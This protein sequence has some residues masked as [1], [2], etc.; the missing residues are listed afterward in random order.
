MALV[1]ELGVMSR[2]NPAVVNPTDMFFVSLAR[3]NF[4]SLMKALC[5]M[6][7]YW[8][9]VDPVISILEKRESLS[10]GL[11]ASDK[12]GSGMTRPDAKRRRNILI[13]LPDLGLLRRFAADKNHPDNIA[14]PTDTSLRDSIARAQQNGPSELMVCPPF[15]IL[16]SQGPFWLADFMSDYVVENMSFVPA[17]V[18]DLERLLSLPAGSG[19]SSA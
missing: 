19:L 18:N 3:Q 7:E 15:A 12:A 17:D 1:Q 14:Q 9:A 11:S 4:A 16:T 2:G 5:R 6:G 10:A 13:S 8:A